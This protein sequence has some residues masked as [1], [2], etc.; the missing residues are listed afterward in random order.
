MNLLTI[1]DTIIFKVLSDFLE[2]VNNYYPMLSNYNRIQGNLIGI[3][4]NL[5]WKQKTTVMFHYIEDKQDNS[6]RK[7]KIRCILSG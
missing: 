1:L 5:L 7:C 2:N 3:Y 4:N 6:Q